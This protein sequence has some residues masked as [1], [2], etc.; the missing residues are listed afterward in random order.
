MPKGY[1]NFSATHHYT[2]SAR[3]HT[4]SVKD[5]LTAGKENNGAYGAEESRT[6]DGPS[7]NGVRKRRHS[8]T[9]TP[10]GKAG[11]SVEGARQRGADQ[12]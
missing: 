10:R 1:T 11:P 3:T 8:Y 9:L 6:A 7:P 4:N 12:A 2:Q 5:G